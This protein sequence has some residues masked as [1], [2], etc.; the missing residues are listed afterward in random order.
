V[1]RESSLV[2]LCHSEGLLDIVAIRYI[3]QVYSVP[4]MFAIIV[5][6]AS[7]TMQGGFAFYTEPGDLR[8]PVGWFRWLLGMAVLL[9]GR[10]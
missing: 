3:P 6:T 2:P 9:K 8:D 1:F 4:S 7:V 10:F 5:K